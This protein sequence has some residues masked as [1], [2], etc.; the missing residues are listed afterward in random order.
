MKLNDEN[1]DYC[2]RKSVEILEGAG[3]EDQRTWKA[4]VIF[5][6]YSRTAVDSDAFRRPWRSLENGVEQLLK[7]LP[8]PSLL[9]TKSFGL[10]NRYRNECQAAGGIRAQREYVRE[11]LLADSDGVKPIQWIEPGSGGTHHTKEHVFHQFMSWPGVGPL[12]ANNLYQLLRR[13]VVS[14]RAAGRQAF[15]RNADKFCCTA[16]GARYFLNLMTAEPGGRRFRADST[17]HR[18]LRHFSGK[19]IYM[20]ARFRKVARGL[21]RARDHVVQALVSDFDTLDENDAVFVFCEA[22]KVLAYL[23]SR[24]SRYLRLGVYEED[25]GDDS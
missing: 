4:Y 13:F 23:A 17:S 8:D 22:W 2:T 3:D 6:T 18:C 15:R 25:D 14:S 9:F 20:W 1:S 12:T 19:G 7:D 21:P 16:A 11:L 10:C 24:D 5:R